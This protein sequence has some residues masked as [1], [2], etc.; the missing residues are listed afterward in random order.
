[1]AEDYVNFL[2]LHAV[3]RAMREA[4]KAY[5]TLQYLMQATGS[6]E[7]NEPQADGVDKAQL[8]Q[9]ANIKDELIVN[10]D[11]NLVLRGQRMVIPTS[12]QQRAV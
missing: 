4:T 11:S 5:A 1:M 12:L 6:G 9:F 3:P 10:S 7:W 8:R 2:S